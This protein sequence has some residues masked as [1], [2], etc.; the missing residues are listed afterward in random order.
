MTMKFA[1]IASHSVY[2]PPL[3]SDP[4]VLDLGANRGEFARQMSDRFG[5]RYFLVE[6]NPRLAERLRAEDRFSVWHCAVADQEGEVK[7]HINQNDLGSSLL[8]LPSRWY[9]ETVAV[10]AR[11]LESLIAEMDVGRIDV[12]KLDIEGAEVAVLRGL[13]D[14]TLGGIGQITVEF[15]SDPQWEYDIHRETEGV[16]RRLIDLGFL[17]LDFSSLTFLATRCDVLFLNRRLLGISRLQGLCWRAVTT[18][19]S[20]ATKIWRSLPDGWRTSLRGALIRTMRS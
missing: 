17:C 11:R 15:H 12:L 16:I 6:A 9:R 5:G 2:V 8:D 10:Q 13:S 18:P 14:S 3:A 7:F 4:V 1:T 19:P 20:F